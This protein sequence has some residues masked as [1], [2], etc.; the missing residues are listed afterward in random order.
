M[1]IEGEATPTISM[2]VYGCTSFSGSLPD[3]HTFYVAIPKKT[4]NGK[5]GKVKVVIEWE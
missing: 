5:P 3:G 1:K 2:F 4:L